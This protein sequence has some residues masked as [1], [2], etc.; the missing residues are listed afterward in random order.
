MTWP[1]WDT[2]G[3]LRVHDA[4]SAPGLDALM[5][6]W[7]EKLTWVPLYALVLLLLVRAY[8]RRAWAWAAA[9]GVAV[10]L[11]DFLSASVIK[12]AVARPRPCRAEDLAGQ[13]RALVDCGPGLSF[14]SSHATNHMALAVCLAVILGRRHP[15]AALAGLLWAASIAYA[16]VYVGLHYPL[17]ALAGMA[18][19]AVLGAGVGWVA[20]RAWPPAQ[21]AGSWPSAEGPPRR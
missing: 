7:R 21:A 2:R 9:A 10:G 17:D 3:F 16:Q 19:G 14:P 5:P 6:F 4:W 18:L 8:G 15:R 1:A 13:V 12:P 11:G 20:R